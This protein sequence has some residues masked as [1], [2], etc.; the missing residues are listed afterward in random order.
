MYSP[1]TPIDY[2]RTLVADT[3]H[4]PLLEAA[5]AIAHDEHPTLDLQSVLSAV[6]LLGK[7][8]ADRCR[9]TSTE[10]R[11]LQNAVAFFYREQRF[12]G[13]I[14]NYYDPANSYIHRVL[15]TRRGI[16]ITLTVI[17]IELARHVG[18]DAGGVSFPGHFMIR[19][20]LHEGPVM[21]DP[22]TGRSLGL[23]SLRERLAAAGATQSSTAEQ[24]VSIE[25]LLRPATPVAILLRM[26]RN[27]REIHLQQGNTE[28][29]ERVIERMRILDPE[30][31]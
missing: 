23:K 26:L 22:F 29:F 1:V 9:E 10:I 20:N 28:A 7:E 17:F 18:L 30:T 15:E 25:R 12:A 19:V 11:R 21:L 8:L 3:D 5:A 27:L 16:P 13:N 6:D 24:S 2:F 14:E 31:R 4:F